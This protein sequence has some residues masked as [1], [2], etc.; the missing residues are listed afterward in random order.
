MGVE[1]GWACEKVK[2]D[3]RDYC[4]YC[5]LHYEPSADSRVCVPLEVTAD[6]YVLSYLYL[7]FLLV[8]FCINIVMVVT[9]K[10]SFNAVFSPIYTAQMFLLMPLFNIE[11]GKKLV[12]FNRLISHTLV[13]MNFISKDLTFFGTERF[14]IFE[15]KQQ[16]K[17]LYLLRLFYGSM[18]ANTRTL[19]FII[20]ITFAVIIPLLPFGLIPQLRRSSSRVIVVLRNIFDVIVLRIGVRFFTLTYLYM[21]LTTFNETINP[22]DKVYEK[23]SHVFACITFSVY[24][25]ITFLIYLRWAFTKNTDSNNKLIYSKELFEGTRDSFIARSYWIVWLARRLIFV[26]LMLSLQDLSELICMI[27]AIFIQVLYI[28]YLCAARPLKDIHLWI[29]EIV[30]ETFILINISSLIYFNSIEEWTNTINMIYIISFVSLNAAYTIMSACKQYC[31][32]I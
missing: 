18:F 11:M 21:L 4:E 22:S 25:F 17:Y 5:R 32:F 20:L 31:R 8:G 10:F 30:N 26:L 23:E 6:V 15:Y 7:A 29:F 9:Y 16:N 3:P 13:S 1:T 14:D 12:S 24:V 27:L 28:T 2:D 19:M